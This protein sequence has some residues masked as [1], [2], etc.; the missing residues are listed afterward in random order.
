MNFLDKYPIT[1]TSQI[2]INHLVKFY[3]QTLALRLK[4]KKDD[5]LHIYWSIYHHSL[6]YAL[7][8]VI[9][10]NIFKGIKIMQEDDTWR[11]AYIAVIASLTFIFLVFEI[12]NWLQF[13]VEQKKEKK[14][15]IHRQMKIDT[16]GK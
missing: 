15:D 6:G 4:P 11:P 10:V 5:E 16:Q 2:L 1:A 3:I 13:K 9:C 8:A 14:D 12:I 7:L